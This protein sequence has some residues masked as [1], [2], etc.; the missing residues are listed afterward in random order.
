MPHLP[1]TASATRAGALLT[2]AEALFATLKQGG[3]LTADRLRDAM[4]GAFGATDADG[5]WTWHDAYEASEAAVTGLR[6]TDSEGYLKEQ[7]PP[8]SQFLNRLLALPIDRQNSLFTE[9]ETRIAAVIEDA[10]CAGSYN[11]GLETLVAESFAVLGRETVHTDPETGA[12]T[13]LVEIRR[14]DPLVPLAADAALAKI[15]R[16]QPR[17][18]EFTAINTRS[19]HAAVIVPATVRMG[20]DGGLVERCRIIHPVRTETI[21]RSALADTWWAPADEAAWRAAWAAEIASLPSH[22][23]TTLWL[24][25]G[26]LLPIW[27][28]LPDHKMRIRRLTTNDGERLLGRVLSEAEAMVFRRTCGLGSATLSAQEVK[29]ALIELGTSFTL[30]NGWRLTR[31]KVMGLHRIEVEGPAGSDVTALKH[32][33]CVTEIIT[34]RTRVFVPLDDIDA[35]GA[36]LERW[37]IDPGHLHAA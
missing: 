1:R 35:L 26:L 11:V 16:H 21:D 18:T 28:L 14:R 5:R 33:G 31:R 4:H 12:R 9:L 7:L 22:T 27:H 34:W 20:E 3:A 2:A 36:V 30:V 37:P 15:D 19:G 6:L 25:T 23:E 29:S 17:A 8:M 13:E 24:V 32:L 10:R